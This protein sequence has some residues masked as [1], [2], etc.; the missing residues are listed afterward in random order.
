[1]L[2]INSVLQQGVA[3][4]GASVRVGRDTEK[5]GKGE[6]S[7]VFE[8]GTRPP[9]LCPAVS[10]FLDGLHCTKATHELSPH[11]VVRRIENNADIESFL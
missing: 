11:S 4:R 2:L 10:K 8:E 3:D 9:R 1:M 5:E 6:N 7:P